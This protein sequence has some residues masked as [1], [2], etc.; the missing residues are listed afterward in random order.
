MKKIFQKTL[1]QKS[2]K[3][4]MLEKNF[5]FEKNLQIKK[6]G[7]K[8]KVGENFSIRKKFPSRKIF[9]NRKNNI[10]NLMKEKIFDSKH[11]KS[12]KYKK[13]DV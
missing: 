2:I 9:V 4:V 7:K 8:F 5:K 12:K 10:R 6:Q 3:N 1:S 11:F 13:F